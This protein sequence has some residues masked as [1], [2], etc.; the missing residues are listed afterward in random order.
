MINKY[1]QHKRPELAPWKGVPSAWF[2]LVVLV[3]F[4]STVVAA[5]LRGWWLIDYWIH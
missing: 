5:T 3:V 4:L 2:L 1:P